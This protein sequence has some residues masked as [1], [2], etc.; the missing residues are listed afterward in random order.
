MISSSS[1]LSLLALG[2]ALVLFP[3]SVQAHN[4][5]LTAP[6]AAPKTDRYFSTSDIVVKALPAPA[7]QGSRAWKRD[8]GRVINLQRFVAEDEILKAR[9]ENTLRPE[10]VTSI[11]GE[12]F[13]REN[14]PATFAVLDKAYGDSAAISAAA[15]AAWQT[16]RPFAVDRRV[17]LK[18][19]QPTSDRLGYPS[20]H[21]TAAHVW[22]A[23]LHDIAP[24]LGDK[25]KG[26]AVGI[27]NRRVLLGVHLL[28][29]AKGGEALAKLIYAR[30]A[31]SPDY[32]A[33]IL[34]ARR[35]MGWKT[36]KGYS[37]CG[38]KMMQ[39]SV[40]SPQARGWKNFKSRV[41]E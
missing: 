5:E 35:E 8:I 15:K 10:I 33:D 4:H 30:L 28:Q 27:A 40:V 24:Q 12:K 29:D 19:D 38:P 18:L 22:A 36:G 9:A 34:L 14:L 39:R 32:Q 13:N 31:A 17:K 1:L 16:P 3:L 20:G 25:A 11:F 23:I 37:D 6:Y 41:T 7:K 2:T 26:Q 21:S